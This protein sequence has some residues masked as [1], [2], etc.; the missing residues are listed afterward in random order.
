MLMPEFILIMNV[1]F[2]DFV[3]VDSV[4]QN[5]KSIVKYALMFSGFVEAELN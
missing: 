1:C 2:A 4:F 5:S 3:N